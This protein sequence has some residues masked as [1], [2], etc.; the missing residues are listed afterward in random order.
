LPEVV[1]GGNSYMITEVLGS[2][3]EGKGGARGQVE[4]LRASEGQ[5][6]VDSADN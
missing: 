2:L 1:Y 6:M 3:R 5:F 4:Q